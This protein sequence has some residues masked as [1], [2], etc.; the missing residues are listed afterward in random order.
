MDLS[1][2]GGLVLD[3]AAHAA[4]LQGGLGEL[5]S[6]GWVGGRRR[7]QRGAALIVL[8]K[9]RP[10]SSC[11]CRIHLL[12]CLAHLDL[13]LDHSRVRQG[14]CV[15]LEVAVCRRTHRQGLS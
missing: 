7:L 11:A 3:R 12:G 10:G 6:G 14:R 15:C 1:D 8:L 9:A 13:L 4:Y 2:G 5:H